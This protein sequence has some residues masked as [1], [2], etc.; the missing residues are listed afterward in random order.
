MIVIKK[1]FTNGLRMF[2][3]ALCVSFLL[4]TV[5]SCKE[6]EEDSML[7]FEEGTVTVGPE[8]GS[9]SI[10]IRSDTQWTLSGAA[11]WFSYTI[12]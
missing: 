4:A 6:K 12:P 9:V 2:K 7:R 3:S 8:S 11:D 1:Y 5:F 10:I